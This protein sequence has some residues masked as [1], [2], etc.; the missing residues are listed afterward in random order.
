MSFALPGKRCSCF[1]LGFPLQIMEIVSKRRELWA[2]I[3][4]EA[5]S[6]LTFAPGPKPPGALLDLGFS[7]VQSLLVALIFLS[8]LLPVD[9]PHML[10]LLLLVHVDPPHRAPSYPKIRTEAA[11]A[12]WFLAFLGRS[13]VNCIVIRL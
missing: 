2:H 6:A 11:T 9:F 4:G 13:L 8:S 5:A 10:L 7:P 1:F 3:L 12:G